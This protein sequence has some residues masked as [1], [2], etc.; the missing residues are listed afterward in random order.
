MLRDHDTNGNHAVGRRLDA[1]C[2]FPDETTEV[3][4]PPETWPDWT[5]QRFTLDLDLDL[6]LD[7]ADDEDLD[8][9]AVFEP[10]PED[11]DAL[12]DLEERRSYEHGCRMKFV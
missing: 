9:P 12:L 10:S 8:A 11:L 1:L 3:F 7:Q 6:D 5:D 4:G 2:E